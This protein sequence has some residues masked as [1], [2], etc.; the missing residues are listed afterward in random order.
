MEAL[1]KVESV[2]FATLNFGKVVKFPEIS[3]FLGSNPHFSGV[4]EMF[5][6]ANVVIHFL[7]EVIFLRNF[8]KIG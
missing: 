6:R 1:I 5:F 3:H 8:T 2:D 4:R 7:V